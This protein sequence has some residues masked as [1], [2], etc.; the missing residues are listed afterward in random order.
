MGLARG[1]RRDAIGFCRTNDGP[2]RRKEG[3]LGRR[4]WSIIQRGHEIRA[5]S[6]KSRRLDARES[7]HRPVPLVRLR[8]IDWRVN[9]LVSW[10]LLALQGYSG[11]LE[12]R[13]NPYF[14]PYIN[15]R[16]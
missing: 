8:P 9:F 15:I 7:R 14:T 4:G 2:S 1:G 6:G 11:D 13:N 16:N 10:S 3:S 12:A 5:E